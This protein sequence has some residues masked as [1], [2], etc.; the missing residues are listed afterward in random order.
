MGAPDPDAIHD[1]LLE[2]GRWHVWYNHRTGPNR[3]WPWDSNVGGNEMRN[4]VK[5]ALAICRRVAR[6]G[7][8]CAFCGDEIG[9]DRRADANYCGERCKRAAARERRKCRPV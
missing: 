2:D 6:D 8:V 3:F 4:R 7:W 9:F 1:V 5:R